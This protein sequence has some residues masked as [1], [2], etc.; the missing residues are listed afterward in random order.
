M[1]VTGA[2]H[3]TG[4]REILETAQ[5]EEESHRNPDLGR[6]PAV[7][8]PHPNLEVPRASWRALSG[9]VYTPA[10]VLYHFQIILIS[11]DGH[12]MNGA[13]SFS[14]LSDIGINHRTHRTP[15]RD[16]F[17]QRAHPVTKLNTLTTKFI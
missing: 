13:K 17:V 7:L 16:T 2:R 5:L 11:V 3:R 9:E 15:R 8:F 12:N 1:E 6:S 10:W 4:H 14:W